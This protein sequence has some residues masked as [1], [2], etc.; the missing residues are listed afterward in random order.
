MFSPIIF[1][2][3]GRTRQTVGAK[4]RGTVRAYTHQMATRLPLLPNSG[5]RSHARR[6]LPDA[7]KQRA[8]AAPFAFDDDDVLEP[9]PAQ[10]KRKQAKHKAQQRPQR[11]RSAGKAG[12]VT[13]RR[14]LSDVSNE[15][16]PRNAVGRKR[17]DQSLRRTPPPQST[18]ESMSISPSPS[19]ASD[20]S[21]LSVDASSVFSMDGFD[22]FN[23]TI[24]ARNVTAT[25]GDDGAN[26]AAATAGAA[27]AIVPLEEAREP[28]A[29]ALAYFAMG[30]YW[31]AEAIMGGVDG[32]CSTTVGFIDGVEVVQVMSDPDAVSYTELL[33]SFREGH[34][35][36][37]RWANRKFQSAIF[38]AKGQLK[39]AKEGCGSAAVHK[40][41]EFKTGKESDQLYYLQQKLPSLL[42]KGELSAAQLGRINHCLAF[43]LPYEHLLRPTPLGGESGSMSSSMRSKRTVSSLRPS[44]AE[45]QRGPFKLEARCP[46]NGP[47]SLNGP[48]PAIEAAISPIAAVAPE[49]PKPPLEA[50]APMRFSPRIV[51]A[52]AVEPQPMGGAGG[53]FC[54][55]CGGGGRAD[56]QL[57][58]SAVLFDAALNQ[59]G[60][61]SKRA[62]AQLQP[63]ASVY[64]A[65]EAVV[66]AERSLL[67]SE[68]SSCKHSSNPHHNLILRGV[69]ERLPVV[70]ASPERAEEDEVASRLRR[71]KFCSFDLSTVDVPRDDAVGSEHAS[72]ALLARLHRVMTAREFLAQDGSGHAVEEA[73]TAVSAGV[74]RIGAEASAVALLGVDETVAACRFFSAEVEA[75]FLNTGGEVRSYGGVSM[76][77]ILT[78]A[79]FP[80]TNQA[81][82]CIYKSHNQGSI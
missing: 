30:C 61:L 56:G 47:C 73:V 58:W 55:R 81:P 6:N 53:G 74:R 3:L 41:G 52:I 13:V 34:E 35:L 1:H 79:C 29:S 65:L 57:P 33:Q 67:Q 12:A 45:E 16:R 9:P 27:A 68:S 24:N 42:K 62:A 76:Q 75:L 31:H 19:D 63:G 2:S 25:S 38:A 23:E 59:L 60:A 71:V 20:S 26:G 15:E 77:A 64:A 39:E 21:L 66:D 5:R 80:G 8:A 17:R 70:T 18:G 49:P 44:S 54:T 48:P 40:V 36:G 14:P 82:A 11:P 37:K 7:Q 43:N 50:A 4:R 22:S 10:A 51:E 28:A 78:T 69:S 72:E 46:L 32:V